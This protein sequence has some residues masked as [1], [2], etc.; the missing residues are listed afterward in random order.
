MRDRGF[1]RYAQSIQ[2]PSFFGLGSG[3][4]D[5]FLQ[6]FKEPETERP[7]HARRDMPAT[8]VAD[9]PMRT[10]VVFGPTGTGSL[11]IGLMHGFPVR[12]CGFDSDRAK[13]YPWI[14]LS[15]S[16]GFPD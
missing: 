15:G 6:S 16:K 1:N 7:I 8:G 9:Q 12:R 2:C 14:I 11:L 13:N 4:D 10:T 5:L 3:A